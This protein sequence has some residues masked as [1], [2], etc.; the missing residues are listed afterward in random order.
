MGDRRKSGQPYRP[1]RRGIRCH[2]STRRWGCTAHP[3]TLVDRTGTGTLRLGRCSLPGT[4]VHTPRS[5]P[6]SCSCPGKTRR[7]TSRAVRIGIRPVRRFR[8][9]HMLARTCRNGS[10]SS[11]DRHT[12]R[13]TR[14]GAP[15]RR[16]GT[17]RS[18]CA[19]GCTGQSGDRSRC[20]TDHRWRTA[21]WRS[22][23]PP[24]RASPKPAGRTRA[25]P[26]PPAAPAAWTQGTR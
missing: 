14:S 5:G 22:C 17:C 20:N 23:R 15:R 2:R 3:R 21:H 18:A 13:C 26:P 7:T 10:G 9:S 8:R 12:R 11:R 16:T 19:G 25:P 1:G 6:N 4:G 24:P